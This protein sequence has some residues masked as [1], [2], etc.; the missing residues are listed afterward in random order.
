MIELKRYE[1]PLDQK[2][3]IG[4]K[5]QWQVRIP[6]STASYYYFMLKEDLYNPYLTNEYVIK[7]YSIENGIGQGAID[8]KI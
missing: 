3:I 5:F 1:D 2:N 8:W 7:D 6:E 4:Y